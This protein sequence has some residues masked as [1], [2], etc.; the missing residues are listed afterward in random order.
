MKY[1][2]K[3]NYGGWKEGD[4]IVFPL[5][6]S[7]E[8]G[9]NKY[10]DYICEVKNGKL[11]QLP[12]L[13]EIEIPETYRAI[14][15][16]YKFISDGTWYVE[17]TEAFPTDEVSDETNGWGAFFEGWTNETYESFKGELPRWDGELCSLDEFKIIKR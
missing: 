9:T 5:S 10:R 8:E 6:N 4:I 16:D 14:R 17:G 1:T 3:I 2:T 12:K 13:E 7:K 15:L 11:L